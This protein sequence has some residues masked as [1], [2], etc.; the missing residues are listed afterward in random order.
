MLELLLQEQDLNKFIERHDTM[1]NQYE[2]DLQIK[3][4]ELE[5]CKRETQALNKELLGMT[6]RKQNSTPQKV[7]FYCK[8]LNP[9]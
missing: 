3:N 5:N 6:P 1:L 9:K 2:R 7:R 8:L 4:Q